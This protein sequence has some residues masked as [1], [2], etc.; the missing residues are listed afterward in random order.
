[1]NFVRCRITNNAISFDDVEAPFIGTRAEKITAFGQNEVI[2]GIRHTHISV[3]KDVKSGCMIG[4][5]FFIE[6][7]NEEML[8]T[9][10]IGKQQLLATIPVDT[11]IK[12]GDAIYAA[13]NYDKCSYFDVDTQKNLL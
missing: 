6:P 1:M 10:K 8:L 5:V 4:E 11:R 12:I 7:R 2:L 9:I 3:S 13:F